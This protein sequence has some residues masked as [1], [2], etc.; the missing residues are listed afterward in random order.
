VPA[1]VEVRMMFVWRDR[2][3]LVNNLVR[4]TKG[5]MV[6]VDFNKD[7]AWVG[8]SLALHS[9]GAVGGP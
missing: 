7:R 1:K 8:S 6:G 5:K 9:P 2:P 4:M 3:L